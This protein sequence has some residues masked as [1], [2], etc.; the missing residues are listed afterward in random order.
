MR[1]CLSFLH[2]DG[3]QQGRLMLIQQAMI[4]GRL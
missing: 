4:D 3:T 2:S 1:D